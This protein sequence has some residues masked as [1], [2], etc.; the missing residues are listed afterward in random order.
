LIIRR[1]EPRRG[2]MHPRHSSPCLHPHSQSAS[3]SA[4]DRSHARTE[5][6]VHAPDEDEHRESV[7]DAQ[8]RQGGQR[9]QSTMLRCFQITDTRGHQCLLGGA[10]TERS[11]SSQAGSASPAPAKMTAPSAAAT[12][13]SK[14]TRSAAWISSSPSKLPPA[15]K[16]PGPEDSSLR[17]RGPVNGNE[18]HRA[19]TNIM[20]PVKH[21]TADGAL[22]TR[23]NAR[24][25]AVC[26]GQP[27]KK[28][29]GADGAGMK[30]II[31]E[32]LNTRTTNFA[33]NLI[34]W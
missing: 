27:G 31:R 33:Y 7:L 29:Q 26:D 28:A 24:R 16:H 13:A 18:V 10:H 9:R 34:L 23:P 19:P 3:K 8:R 12:A 5:G 2:R 6:R 17:L 14:K 30:H 21:T 25:D 32:R 1:R 20:P 15:R 4:P 22:S 11:R